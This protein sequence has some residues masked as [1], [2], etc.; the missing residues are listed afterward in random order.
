MADQP[1]KS[2]KTEEPSAKKLEDAHKK[3]DVAKSQE[4]TTWFMILASALLFAIMGP[5]TG[6][7]LMDNLKILIANA[8][9]FEIGGQGLNSFVNKLTWTIIG[10]VLLPLGLMAFAAIGANLIQHKPVLSLDPI[11]PKLSKISPI[12]GFKRL[13]STESLMN[14]AKGLL[15]LTI[16]SIVMFLVVWPQRDRLETIITLEPSMILPVFLE[17][18]I[19][20]FGATLAI[21]TIIAFADYLYQRH[22]WW[23]KQK[24]TIKEV[25]DE[26]K[27]MEGDPQIKSRIRQI[28][29]ER[30]QK[31]MMAAVP[32]ATVVITNPTH[33]AVALKY[34]N[35]TSAPVC[36]AKGA[37]KIALKIRELAKN[38]EVPIVENPPLARAL[39]A[40]VELDETIPSE[41]FKAVASVIGYVMRLKQNKAWRA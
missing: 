39:F 20:I 37:D 17:L 19:K 4:V 7:S 26:Y 18:G 35:T 21:I 27:Q 10:V 15:K 28:R 33:Y 29:Q 41:H 14:F 40:S 1:D 9:Q 34:D 25:R 16:V 5:I 36:I 31:R 32:E 3:G 11:K 23:E 24:M 2:E 6:A 8:D 13:F 12:S 38:N 30:A 22:K